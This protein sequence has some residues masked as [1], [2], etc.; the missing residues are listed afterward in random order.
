MTYQT[1]HSAYLTWWGGL[2][3]KHNCVA[4]SASPTM[5]WG[6]MPMAPFPCLFGSHKAC[7][8]HSR[9]N[10]KWGLLF[11]SRLYFKLLAIALLVPWF[12]IILLKLRMIFINFFYNLLLWRKSTVLCSPWTLTKLM[13][14]MVSNQFSF[15]LIGKSLLKIPLRWLLMLS[16]LVIL[17]PFWH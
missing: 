3:R 11:F 7:S 6:P 4:W 17:I 15:D 8:I 12:S 13:G 2:N 1:C 5:M 9:K 16:V 14:Q 10:K